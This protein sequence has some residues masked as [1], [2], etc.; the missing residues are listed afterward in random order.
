[1]G[2]ERHANARA[3][4]VGYPRRGIR[5]TEFLYLHNYVPARW[6][7]GDPPKFGDV[8]P[9]SGETG[10]G[11][12]KD[13]ILAHQDDPVY[14]A[15]YEMDF[16]KTPEEE[17]FDVKAD[18]WDQHNLASDPKFSDAKQKLRKELDDYLA[19]THDPRSSTTQPAPFDE[20]PYYGGAG[21]YGVGK[22]GLSQ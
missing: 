8:D 17:L 4:N 11:L 16:A 10:D 7:A 9:A 20:Y 12:S 18:P 21:P 15:F 19:A 1:M 2:N 22:K 5:T 14:R 13:F 6:P 3:G